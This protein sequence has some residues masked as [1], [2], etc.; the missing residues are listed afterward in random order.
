MTGNQEKVSCFLRPFSAFW[1]NRSIFAN[2]RHKDIRCQNEQDKDVCEIETAKIKHLLSQQK[3]QIKQLEK[4]QT[5]KE[6]ITNV[7]R[8]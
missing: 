5:S 7:F 6:G 8:L 2:H 3:K 4:K 1:K